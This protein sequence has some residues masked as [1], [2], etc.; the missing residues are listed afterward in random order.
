MQPS[1]A[2]IERAKYVRTVLAYHGHT[3]TD[4]GR[5]LGVSQVSASHKL[6]GTR[7]FKTSELLIIADAYDLDPG[8]LLR[9]P[10]LTAVLGRVTETA[11]DLLTCT[12]NY[13]PWSEA[14]FAN[15]ANGLRLPIIR[16]MSGCSHIVHRA[17]CE[18]APQGRPVWHRPRGSAGNPAA[19]GLDRHRKRIDNSWVCRYRYLAYSGGA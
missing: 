6:R 5:L 17:Q 13:L 18:I 11:A 16:K 12:Y 4:L 14:L 2:D 8:H 10:E 1:E 9:P 7:A 19:T 15:G 3:Q